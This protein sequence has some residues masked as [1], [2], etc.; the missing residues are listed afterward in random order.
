MKNDGVKILKINLTDAKLKFDIARKESLKLQVQT[1]S[2][3]HLPKNNEDKTALYTIKIK[4]NTVDTDEIVIDIVSDVI[5]EFDEIP[6]DYDVIS[7]NVCSPMATNAVLAKMD[8]MI[9]IM[10]YPKFN[11]EV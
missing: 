6:E 1:D 5:F 9:E 7:E 3:L 8:D 2:T 11:I 4:M 10:G